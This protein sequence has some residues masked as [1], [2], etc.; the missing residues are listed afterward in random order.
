MRP[1]D[2]QAHS[3]VSS[4]KQSKAPPRWDPK[5]ASQSIPVHQRVSGDGTAPAEAPT[6]RVPACLSCQ[7]LKKLRASCLN[8]SHYNKPSVLR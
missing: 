6:A 2:K 8:L 4:A 7:G 3:D 5:A 1:A